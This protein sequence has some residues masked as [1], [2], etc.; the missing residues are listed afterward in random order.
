[1]CS[2]HAAWLTVPG[3]EE[4]TKGGRGGLPEA[5]QVNNIE[6]LEFDA[7]QLKISIKNSSEDLKGSSV[8]L[9]RDTCIV[10][11][12]LVV[13]KCCWCVPKDVCGAQEWASRHS[14]VSLSS[15]LLWDPWPAPRDRSYHGSRAV[16]AGCEWLWLLRWCLAKWCLA[17]DS[18]PWCCSASKVRPNPQLR[19]LP[20]S[21]ILLSSWSSFAQTEGV[22]HISDSA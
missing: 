10:W 19:K 4:S 13:H 12:G 5:E 17:G 11:G 8:Q 1:M 20:K 18:S 15:S 22:Q 9:K 7:L 3:W 21:P 14:F 6:I 2:E 16:R